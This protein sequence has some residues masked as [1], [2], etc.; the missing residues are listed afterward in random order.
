MLHSSSMVYLKMS[1]GAQM[2]SG[3]YASCMLHLN[4]FAPGP[5]GSRWCPLIVMFALMCV[6]CV[7][8]RLH[9]HVPLVILSASLG[10]DVLAL[11]PLQ[12]LGQEI[13]RC[14]WCHHCRGG[15][16]PTDPSMNQARSWARPVP[17]GTLRQLCG[18]DGMDL[19]QLVVQPVHL[20][21]RG[22]WCRV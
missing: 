5:L 13:S 8:F 21:D 11:L 16:L 10:F 1:F 15:P 4:A 22:W 17:V 7:A 19:Y 14:R 12:S 20:V 18:A 3:C 9:A 6:P 2:G